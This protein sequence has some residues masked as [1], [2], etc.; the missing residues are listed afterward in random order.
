ML[1][2]HQFLSEHV[3]SIGF[4]SEQEHMREKHRDGI[5]DLLR[6]AYKNMDGYL[7]KGS[8]TKE[9]SEAIHNAITDNNIKAVIR[10]GKVSA[11]NLY[12]NRFGRKSIASASDGS[13]QG[14]KDYI[15]IKTED[16]VHKRAWGEVSGKVEH[17]L[18][19]IGTPQIPADKAEHLTGDKVE[20]LPG[21]THYKR[22]IGDSKY[23]KTIL[24][25]PKI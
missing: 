1:T 9:E 17:I 7:G 18:R 15:K 22:N 24:G 23:T 5:H 20:I 13:I 21:N 12:K 16:N 19:K 8:G 25:H 10:N 2:F 4:N 3:V 11:V 14:K 6:S